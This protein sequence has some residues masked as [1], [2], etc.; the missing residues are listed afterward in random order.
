MCRKIAL[1][2]L[3]GL[4]GGEHWKSGDFLGSGEF[5]KEKRQTFLQKCF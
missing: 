4:L 2:L 1:G 3:Q 5:W